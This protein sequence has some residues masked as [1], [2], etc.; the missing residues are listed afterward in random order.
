MIVKIGRPVEING[1]TD[2]RAFAHGSKL[3]NWDLSYERAAAAREILE[4]HGVPKTQ[5]TGLFARAATQLY[6]P[7]DPYAAQNRRLSFLLR[8]TPATTDQPKLD[9]PIAIPADTEVPS[10]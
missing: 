7:S 3:N 10:R 6:V 5:I 1:H 9:K 2:A 8:V 4:N